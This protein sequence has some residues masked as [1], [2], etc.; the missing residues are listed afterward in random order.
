MASEL[1]AVSRERS[2]ST[3]TLEWPYKKFVFV[4]LVGAAYA[5][6]LGAVVYPFVMYIWG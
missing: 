3:Q 1:N 2:M 6:A 4:T 5:L